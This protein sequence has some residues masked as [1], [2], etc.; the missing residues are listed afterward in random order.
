MQEH[1]LPEL[2]KPDWSGEERMLCLQTHWRTF[3]GKRRRPQDWSS[4]RGSS[5][6]SCKFLMELMIS[7]CMSL[8]THTHICTHG[9][10]VG[11]K[12]ED[13]E[14]G[15]ENGEKAK[16]LVKYIK[17]EIKKKESVKITTVRTP[18]AETN[19]SC[20]PR[21]YHH[22]RTAGGVWYQHTLQISHTAHQWNTKSISSSSRLWT[23]KP[24][25]TQDHPTML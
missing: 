10:N 18:A 23:R 13:G 20:Y 11:G 21:Q 15:E 4:L 1:V 9:V 8:I 2:M 19:H 6:S 5:P 14:Q 25:D 3:R 16:N 17:H 24:R 7:A 12:G 22:Y